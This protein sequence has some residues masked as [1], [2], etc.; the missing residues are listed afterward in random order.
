MLTN[1]TDIISVSPCIL[2]FK[3]KKRIPHIV[4][5]YQY[6]IDKCIKIMYIKTNKKTICHAY[7]TV[8]TIV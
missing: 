8:P 2:L 1:Q 6:K 3:K 5:V 4:A 7:K